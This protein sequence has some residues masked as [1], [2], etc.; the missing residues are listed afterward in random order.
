MLLSLVPPN[1]TLHPM[2]MSP[3]KEARLA[4]RAANRDVEVR[5]PRR[6][7]GDRKRVAGVALAAL[8]TILQG[9]PGAPRVGSG[10][11]APAEA[12]GLADDALARVLSRWNPQL[13]RPEVMR[14]ARA[15]TRYSAK[16]ELDPGL[17]A[18]VIWVESNAHPAARSPKGAMGLMQ[19]MPHMLEPLRLAGNWTTVE[20]NIE[21]GCLI[22]ADNIRRWGEEDGILAYFWG[23]DIRGGA[24]LERVRAARDE[25]RRL[26]VSS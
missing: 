12:R 23:S 3:S 18:A 22:L 20:S 24:Y 25:V 10:P 11:A 4:V 19:V 14:I 6:A 9:A 1:T 15:V 5:A 13:S 16:Y 21:A 26:L 7:S 2:V 17:V 8:L